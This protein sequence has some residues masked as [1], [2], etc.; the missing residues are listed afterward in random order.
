MRKLSPLRSGAFRFSLM[1]TGIFVVGA[2]ALLFLADRAV[3][4]YASEV[5]RDSVA[6]DVAELSDEDRASDRATG[7]ERSLMSLAS[8]AGHRL[9]VRGP[10]R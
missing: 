2:M 7:G 4:G 5:A 10:E 8:A 3:D 9:L 6:A 1:V